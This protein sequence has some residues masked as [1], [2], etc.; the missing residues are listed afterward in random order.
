[1]AKI[2]IDKLF[3]FGLGLF[4]ASYA[5]SFM[6]HTDNI[7]F[8]LTLS[9]SVFMLG[10][11]FMGDAVT[12]RLQNKSLLKTL[13][14]NSAAF[15]RFMIVST[16][17]AILLEGI[18]QWLGKLWVYP[19]LTTNKYLLVFVLGFMA[20][21]L[22]VVESYLAVK[23]ILDTLVRV[24]RSHD[25]HSA[26]EPAFF[27]ALGVGGLVLVT[28][29]VLAIFYDYRM[30]G[31]YVFNITKVVPYNVKFI[32]IIA[33]FVGVWFIAEFFEFRHKQTSL[34]KDI[35]HNYMTPLVAIV[36]SSVLLALF[37]EL[38]NI[39]HGYWRYMHW[40]F[41][42]LSFYGLPIVMVFVAWPLHYIMFLSVFRAI[43]P[44]EAMEV[45]RLP[46]SKGRQ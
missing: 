31:G 6:L 30:I 26:N 25:R 41:E 16:V 3:L 34:M 45:W 19:Y 12:Q 24:R 33:L 9:W 21:W 44:K 15:F 11:I 17:G 46:I 14:R 10:V 13:K 42:R 29:S 27:R 22:M 35:L 18:A 37:M 23:S 1:M 20:Y 36:I 2:K 5:Q 8:V 28:I 38:N 43:T 7:F 32:Y 4:L 40:P 39:R